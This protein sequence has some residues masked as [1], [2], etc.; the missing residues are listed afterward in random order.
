MKRATF[1]ALVTAGRLIATL[2]IA[3]GCARRDVAPNSP[4]LDDGRQWLGAG[5]MPAPT[6]PT[7]LRAAAANALNQTAV[8]ESLLVGMVRSQP[9]SPSASRAH[10]LLT[11][12]YVRTGQYQRLI[13]NLDDWSRAFP[14]DSELQSARPDIE[15][16]RGLPD[17]INGPR[18]LST[19]EHGPSNEF[20][21][22][23]LIDGKSATYLLDTG[24]WLSV[25]TS[26][27]AKRLGLTIRESSLRTGETSGKGVSLRTAV[28]KEVVLGS[29][30]FHDVSF[31]IM[32]DVEPWT[33]MTPGRGGII[34][35]PI[36]LHLGCIRWT[37]GGNWEFGCT[38]AP[39]P[40][41]ANMVFYE[42]HLLV[43]S[44][45][46]DRPVFM[47]LDT[48]AETTDLN[49]SF[50]RQFTDQVQRMSVKD[51]TRVSGLG[52]SSAL[53]SMTL[54]AVDFRIGS[55]LATLRPA[56]VTMQE[57]RAM[58]GG[59]CV[60]NIGLDLLLQ[61]DTLTVDF[62]RMTLRVR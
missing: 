3:L 47:T 11:R 32:P 8:S 5:A 26:A 39:D 52:G 53:E 15:Q 22:P 4:A 14:T 24:A 20:S 16:F 48:G 37:R 62:S 18:Q 46:W 1:G 60:G 50:A 12:L 36:L 6:A 41:A 40:H 57:N 13:A 9:T 27:E 54:P 61:T 23:V 2:S 38:T 55:G 10:S 56:H 59:C 34:G 51:T 25:M 28:A 19:L 31:G 29:T 7:L 45:A 44:S 30:V 21:A 58:G 49:A 17:Q 33:S 43:A 35:I 42:N